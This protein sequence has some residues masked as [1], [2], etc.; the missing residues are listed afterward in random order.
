MKNF[1]VYRF[2]YKTTVIAP[3]SSAIEKQKIILALDEDDIRKN[4]SRK[5]AGSSIQIISIEFL[6]SVDE[7][8]E[9]DQ[10]NKWHIQSKSNDNWIEG[11]FD[12][13]G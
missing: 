6:G 8:I 7:V 3:N 12:D 10:N 5:I 9:K 2:V 4:Y 1:N 11:E 13:C